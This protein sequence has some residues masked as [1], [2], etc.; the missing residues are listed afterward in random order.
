MSN[1]W[2]CIRLLFNMSHRWLCITSFPK[3]MIYCTVVHF[4]WNPTRLPPSKRLPNTPKH[5]FPI[6]PPSNSVLYPHQR[7]PN[8]DYHHA[9]EFSFIIIPRNL[10]PSQLSSFVLASSAMR[11]CYHPSPPPPLLLLPCSP[12][13]ILEVGQLG[14]V[15]A[16]SEKVKNCRNPTTD[17]SRSVWTRHV[18]LPALQQGMSQ[19][20]ENSQRGHNLKKLSPSVGLLSPPPSRPRT[21][22]N[23]LSQ[24]RCSRNCVFNFGPLNGADWGGLGFDRTPHVPGLHIETCR[25]G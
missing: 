9:G 16:A 7:L 17:S 20:P 18:E 24:V 12:V 6:F 14:T 4:D 8:M 5:P 3:T 2:L 13:A 15:S 22:T 11:R 10:S 23:R 21:K 19:L 25:G 1:R